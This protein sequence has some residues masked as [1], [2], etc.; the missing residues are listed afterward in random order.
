MSQRCL[1]QSFY[2]IV[3][4]LSATHQSFQTF[5]N[6]FKIIVKTFKIV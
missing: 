4:K 1:R 3:K 2:T 6:R 5:F